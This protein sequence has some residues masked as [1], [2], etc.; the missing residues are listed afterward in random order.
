MGGLPVHDLGRMKIIR[1]DRDD[2]QI[3]SLESDLMEFERTVTKY[4]Q[5]L[6]DALL[7]AA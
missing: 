6:R 1:I 7:E 3:E 2:N 4:Q 5:E